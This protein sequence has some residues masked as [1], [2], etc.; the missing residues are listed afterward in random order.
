MLLTYLDESFTK[1]RY[2]IA[3]LA[4]PEHEAIPLALALDHIVQEATSAYATDPRAELHGHAL[5]HGKEDWTCI[6]PKV[7]ARIGHL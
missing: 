5:F 3:G 4:C 1:D 2:Y 7:R 6:A